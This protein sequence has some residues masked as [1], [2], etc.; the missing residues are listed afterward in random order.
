MIKSEY[1]EEKTISTSQDA[2]SL[3]E[4]SRF[5]EKIDSRIEYSLIESIYLQKIKKIKVYQR[6]KEISTEELIKKAKRKDKKIKTRLTVFSD[7]RK[8]GYIV[9]TA[10]KFGAEFRVYDKGVKPGKDHARWIL[11][12]SRENENLTWHDFTSK[13]RVAHSTKKKLLLGIVDDEESV[14]YYEVSWIKT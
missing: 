11:F 14:S 13:N 7:L 3:Y 10:L 2:F 1:T 8:K 6:N 4:K 5:G 9:K 12:T